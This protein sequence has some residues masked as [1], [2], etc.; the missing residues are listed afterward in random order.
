METIFQ[1]CCDIIRA[2]SYTFGITYEE[3]NTYLF[4]YAQPMILI[5]SFVIVI[6]TI[7]SK[8]LKKVSILKIFLLGLFGTAGFLYTLA[9]LAVW[10]RYSVLSAHDTCVLSYKDLETLG[11]ITGLGYIGINLFLFIVLFLII[12]G[13]NIISA[14]L[15]KKYVKCYPK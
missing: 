2:L 3:M 14:F 13:F 5:I 1:I 10:K 4:I 6:G 15:I 8:L 11:K 7:L 12:L 9:T